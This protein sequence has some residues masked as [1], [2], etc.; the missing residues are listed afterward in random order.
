MKLEEAIIRVSN[1]K[2]LISI[3]EDD[4][5]IKD[6]EAIDLVL[7]ELDIKDCKIEILNANLAGYSRQVEKDDKKIKEQQKDLEEYKRML[8]NS[9]SKDKIRTL[10]EKSKKILDECNDANIREYHNQRISY[11]EELL[12][13]E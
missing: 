2:G 5:S 11:F 7:K 8:N 3:C 13:E 1:I 4:E 6:F 9:I 10:I 12:K